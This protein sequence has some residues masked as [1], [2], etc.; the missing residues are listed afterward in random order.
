MPK[1]SNTYKGSI[2][3]YPED[4]AVVNYIFQIWRDIAQ[5]FGYLEYNSG[6][7]EPIEL[8]LDKT[9]EE[10][11]STQTYNFIDRGGRN[12]VLRPEMT[13]TIARMIVTR[14]QSLSKPIRWFAIANCFRYERPQKGRQREFWQFNADLFGVSTYQG[15]LEIIRLGV[16]I[17]QAFGAGPND[18]I[19]KLNSRQLWNFILKEYLAVE[20]NFALDLSRLL[21]RKSKISQDSYYQA[22]SEKL[23]KAQIQRLEKFLMVENIDQLKIFFSE[24]GLSC[25]VYKNLELTI[26]G[27]RS[28]EYNFVLDVSLM[29]G[30][31]YY[32]DIVFEFFDTNPKN[33]RSMFG[34]GRY[35]NLIADIGGEPLPAIGFGL[36]EAGLK[37]FLEEHQLIPDLS[38]KIDVYI[39]ICDDSKIKQANLVATQKRNQGL[40]V[41]VDIGTKSSAKAQQIANKHHALEFIY[42]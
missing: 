41:L 6:I 31:D 29:R 27:L 22:L 10:I 42:F 20:P 13:P 14:Q 8:Y 11:V 30:F 34:G 40:A 4:W 36:G 3:Y 15:E 24:E 23:D 17:L 33:P 16:S 28:E 18:Y 25:E 26:E 21:D 12:V 38:P 7:L 1:S 9:S 5:K 19:I 37:I 32:T 2:D 39:Y 35:D